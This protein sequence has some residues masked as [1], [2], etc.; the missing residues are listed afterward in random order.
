MTVRELIAQLQTVPGDTPVLKA[1][2]HNGRLERYR[3]FDQ[4]IHDVAVPRLG[5]MTGEKFW[6]E[7][8]HDAEAGQVQI[9]VL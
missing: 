6:V 3:E 8:K 4:I 5:I 9:V 2:Y 1:V 7:P